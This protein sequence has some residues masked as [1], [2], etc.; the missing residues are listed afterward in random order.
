MSVV[1][2]VILALTLLA[3]CNTFAELFTTQT[4][5]DALQPWQPSE[6]KENN[7]IINVITHVE[8]LNRENYAPIITTG[9]CPPLWEQN[10]ETTYLKSVTE[11]RIFSK[12]GM[13]G[14]TLLNPW[15]VCMDIRHADAEQATSVLFANSHYYPVKTGE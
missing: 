7:G 6:I 5:A 10:K 15:K 8:E 12:Y 2:H 13:V 9:V 1:K 3:S 14:Y 4:L 11:I